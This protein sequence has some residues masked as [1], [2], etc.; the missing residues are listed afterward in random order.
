LMKVMDDSAEGI[1]S[2]R[3]DMNTFDTINF[4]K[5]L[6]KHGGKLKTL[7]FPAPK[8]NMIPEDHLINIGKYCRNLKELEIKTANFGKLALVEICEGCVQL[9]QLK[10]ENCQSSNFSAISQLEK[11][12]LLSLNESKVTALDLTTILDSL[13]RISH[14]HLTV[15]NIEESHLQQVSKMEDLKVFVSKTRK[16]LSCDALFKRKGVRFIVV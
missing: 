16:K 13:K 3:F 12:T 1:S 8:S 7:L 15:Y 2:L 11:L 14:I 5:I 10:L 6:K 9:E 4:E